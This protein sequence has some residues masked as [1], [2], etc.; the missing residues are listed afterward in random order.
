MWRHTGKNI[1]F[2]DTSIPQDMEKR[3]NELGSNVVRLQSPL[4]IINLVCYKDKN[5]LNKVNQAFENRIAIQNKRNQS[6]EYIEFNDLQLSLGYDESL[7]F[8]Q[9]S[10]MPN[11]NPFNGKKINPTR[12][13]NQKIDEV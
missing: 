12:Y 9:W 11:F 8:A 1:Y 10:V 4:P 7:P 2:K 3:I 13:N 5:S 6:I